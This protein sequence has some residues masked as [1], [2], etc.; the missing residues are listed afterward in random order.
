VGHS[1]G[2]N[3]GFVPSFEQVLGELGYSNQN[4]GNS[5]VTT[6]THP[7]IPLIHD[8]VTTFDGLSAIYCAQV[9][10]FGAESGRK[11]NEKNETNNYPP[12]APYISTILHIK[13]ILT[14]TLPTLMLSKH[15]LP[16]SYYTQA[17]SSH[18]DP[19][20]FLTQNNYHS[21][22]LNPYL[23]YRSSQ[24]YL[25][26]ISF[27]SIFSLSRNL[28]TSNITPQTE[29]VLECL[30]KQFEKFQKFE[31][32]GSDFEN[33]E[34]FSHFSNISNLSNFDEKKHFSS[35]IS[36]L[37]QNEREFLRNNTNIND[38]MTEFYKRY[39]IEDKFLKY[40]FAEMKKMY[41]KKDQNLT[42]NGPET[43]LEIVQRNQFLFNYFIQR[44]SDE[45]DTNSVIVDNNRLKTPPEMTTTSTTT[46]TA[47]STHDVLPLQK[48]SS[49]QFPPLPNSPSNPHN[50]DGT[51]Q[52]KE[53]NKIQKIPKKFQNLLELTGGDDGYDQ[54]HQISVPQLS[55]LE[56]TLSCVKEHNIVLE[57][58][59]E[60]LTVQNK[61]QDA[62][63]ASLIMMFCLPEEQLLE[64]LARYDK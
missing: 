16:K 1:L 40:H 59:I 8:F 5:N 24:H 57:N 47:T 54:L 44:Y 23:S 9:E 2:G 4:F 55:P 30:E 62:L 19:Q 39:N 56:L 37:S 35:F 51:N 7:D 26:M 6:T 31:F 15:F 58:I 11:S 41:Q 38:G 60:L 42:Q 22:F 12:L 25:S 63:L 48:S 36:S 17:N 29:L 43:P 28:I 34:N 21:S 10:M 27:D 14:N 33:F 49:N 61:R 32:L 52:P 13:N 50:I 46:T 53:S 3:L 45:I 64:V 18:H 20:H